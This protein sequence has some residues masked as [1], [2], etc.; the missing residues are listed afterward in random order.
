MA[1]SLFSNKIIEMKHGNDFEQPDLL[2]YKIID[3]D[4]IAYLLEF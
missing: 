4:P 1:S 2:K 3:G